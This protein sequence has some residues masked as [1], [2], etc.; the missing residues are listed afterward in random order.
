MHAVRSFDKKPNGQARRSRK[1]TYYRAECHMERYLMV[2]FSEATSVPD[3]VWLFVDFA[4]DTLAPLT[5][6]GWL[7]G[8][9]LEL[10]TAGGVLACYLSE[11]S[12]LPWPSDVT[13]HLELLGEAAIL[14][15]YQLRA[16][17]WTQS[18]LRAT[19]QLLFDS[20]CSR[21]ISNRPA[22]AEERK[23]QHLAFCSMQVVAGEMDKFLAPKEV[24]N[25]TK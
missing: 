14:I 12:N 22:T 25:R 20:C 1:E 10:F 13:P 24:G 19:L 8:S 2:A 21:W 3:H 11:K 5:T 16:H 17:T 23:Q 7:D 6:D 9:H 15:V 4:L 18:R